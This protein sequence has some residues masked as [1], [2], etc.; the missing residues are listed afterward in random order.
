LIAPAV[1]ISAAVIAAVNWLALLNVVVLATP[2]KFTTDVEMKFVPFTVRVNAEP[3]AVTL[4][5]EID[6]TVGAGLLIVKDCAPEVPPPGAGFVTV[7]FADPAA[8][9]SEARIA[10]VTFVELTNVVDRAPPLKFTVD[11]LTKLLP[12]TVSVKAPEFATALVGEMELSVGV[13]L[14]GLLIVNTRAPDV[15]PPGAGFVTVTFTGPAVEI[16]AAGIVATICV[17]VVEV[18]V[19]A[20]LPPKFTVAPITK[21]LPLTVSVNAPEFAT[22]LE[23]DRELTE[24]AALFTVKVCAAD[25]PPPGA[26]FVT[27]TLSDPAVAS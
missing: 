16:S 12:F 1:A 11:P 3:P 22:A 27:V 4:A 8:A 17:L 21:L 5:G 9:I 15:P 24:G 2:L 23:G 25:V 18:G 19:I 20:P 26:G 14:L 6:A 7:T 10:A 13:G